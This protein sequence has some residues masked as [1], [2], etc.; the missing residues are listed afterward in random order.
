MVSK[1]NFEKIISDEDFGTFLF[2]FLFY[3]SKTL[4][5]T[6]NLIL[7]LKILTKKGT[8]TSLFQNCSN[9]ETF[10]KC[11]PSE[12]I[13]ASCYHYMFNGTLVTNTDVSNILQ[14]ITR[15]ENYS[16]CGMFLNCVNITSVNLMN[17]TYNKNSGMYAMFLNCKQLNTVYVPR[18]NYNNNQDEF[19]I[20]LQDVSTTGTIYIP[21]DVDWRTAPR[22]GDGIPAGWEIKYIDPDTMEERESLYPIS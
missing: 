1:D 12:R 8:Y 11:L 16:C 14:N 10:I 6:Q 19:Y 13:Y 20:W 7:P 5:N 4:I 2:S 3:N 17:I 9:I 18:L 15:C 22:N 21:Y